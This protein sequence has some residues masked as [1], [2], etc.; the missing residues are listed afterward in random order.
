[1]GDRGRQLAHRRDAVGVC[2]L[3]LRFG[4]MGFTAAQPVFGLLGFIDINRQSVPLDDVSLSIAQRLTAALVPTIRAVRPTETEHTPIRRSGLNCVGEGSFSFRDVVRVYECQPTTMLEVLKWLAEIVQ[5]TLVEIGRLA[6]R[7]QRP[8]ETW[9]SFD[10]LTE[11]VFALPQRI[12]GALAILDVIGGPVPLDDLA[13]LV[14]R[15]HTID[16]EPAILS[17][18]TPDTLLGMPRLAGGKGVTPHFI[19]A[20][21]VVGMRHGGPLR[22]ERSLVGKPRVLFPGGVNEVAPGVCR[23]ARHRDGDGIDHLPQLAPRLSELNLSLAQRIFHALAL[24]QIEHECDALVSA[25]FKCCP[26]YQYGHT[27]TVFSREFLF[28]RLEPAAAFLLFDPCVIPVAPVRRRQV[29]P[30]YAA[31]NQVFAVVAH[32]AKKFVVGLKNA[33][34]EIP[35]ENPD[36]VGI[37]QAP[38]LRFAF[39]QCFLG[40]LAVRQIEHERDALVAALFEQRA[41]NQHRCAAAILSEKLLLVGPRNRI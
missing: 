30:P 8:E 20:R 29:R 1:M 35:D 21:D 24:R 40:A 10:D 15:S 31:R 28:E 36:D 16:A 41:S 17:V 12:L 27:A 26:P 14:A 4:Q 34:V 25:L 32:H 19:A 11:P 2:K 23:I 39:P 37:D 9:Y 22:A 7:G 6:V 33:T 5:K 38:D 13:V 18:G 3:Q